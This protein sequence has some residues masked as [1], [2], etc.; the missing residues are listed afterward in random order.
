MKKIIFFLITTASLLTA[1]ANHADKVGVYWK[2]FKTFEK[3]GVEGKFTELTFTP[4][5]QKT[6]DLKDLLLGSKI[7]I[8]SS[9]IETNN[10]G[11]NKKVSTLFFGNLKGKTIEGEIVEAKAKTPSSGTLVVKI[12]M[13]EKDVK[14]PMS[15]SFDSKH[16]ELVANGVLDIFDF[17]GNDALKAINKECFDLHKGKTWNDVEIEFRIN[18]EG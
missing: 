6:K 7:S 3:I 4:K 17:S 10:V 9:K 2:A 14:V 18:I 13:N 5:M 15:Y 12:T 1:G 16:S 8:N 11:R